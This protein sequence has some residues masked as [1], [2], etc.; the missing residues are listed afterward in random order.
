LNGIT[1]Q[2]NVIV[3]PPLPMGGI[4]GSPLQW[5]IKMHRLLERQ[6]RRNFG[7]IELIPQD[8]RAFIAAVDEAYIKADSDT[9]LVTRS[10]DIMSDE[11][12]QRNEALSRERDEQAVLIGK[13]EF[14]HNQLL[15]SEKMASI[16]QLAAGVAHEINNPIGYVNSNISALGGYVNELI[17]M[18]GVYEGAE[19]ALDPV[20]RAT[21]AACRARLDIDLLKSDIQDILSESK[22]GIGRVKKI[23]QDLKDFSHPDEGKFLYANVHHGILSTLNIVANEIRYKADVITEF[24]DIPEVECILSQLNQV[25]MNLLVNAAHAMGSE[26]R[27]KILVRSGN[28]ADATI[29][30]EIADDGCGIPAENLKKIFDPFFT[31]K[32]VGQGTGL[33][34]SLSYGMVQKHHGNISV[35]SAP[36]QGTCFRITLP[37]RQPAD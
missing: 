23:V 20:A 10:L 19:A 29:W 28:G 15:Q 33:G 11:L 24:G 16:G 27:G 4:F 36:G 18:L 34:L 32:P 25:F 37:I 14:A 31:T 26:R 2:P 12:N 3:M 30:I 8:W 21:V 13:L 17:E 9:A 5:V 22:E 7:S 1:I 6:I 35:H